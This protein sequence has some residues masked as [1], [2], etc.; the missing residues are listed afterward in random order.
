MPLP[1]RTLNPRTV[2]ATQGSSVE[3]ISEERPQAL[4]G[5]VSCVPLGDLQG[6][7]ERDL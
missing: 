6:V 1:D 7:L 5:E 3:P 4:F 2:T